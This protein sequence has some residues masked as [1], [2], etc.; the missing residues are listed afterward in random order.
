V[1][2]K[3]SGIFMVKDHDRVYEDS[4][5]G[6]PVVKEYK[7]LGV[8]INNHGSMESQLKCIK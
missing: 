2:P 8:L 5:D 1:N 7:Y 6:I 3:K 4:I